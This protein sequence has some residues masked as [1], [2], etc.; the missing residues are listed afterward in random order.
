MIDQHREVDVVGA[1]IEALDPAAGAGAPPADGRSP[2]SSQ[3]RAATALRS[4]D[5]SSPR[6][7]R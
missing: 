5:E 2:K 4:F 3:A 7:P 1:D 6:P